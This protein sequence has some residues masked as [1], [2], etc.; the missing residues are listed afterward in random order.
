MFTSLQKLHVSEDSKALI[1][2]NI[3][4]NADNLTPDEIV[5]KYIIPHGYK[6]VLLYFLPYLY[7]QTYNPNRIIQ[8]CI[9]HEKTDF[10]DFFCITCFCNVLSSYYGVELE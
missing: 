3:R 2:E 8:A 6:D 9:E 7:T 5:I 4:I 1:L 10:L